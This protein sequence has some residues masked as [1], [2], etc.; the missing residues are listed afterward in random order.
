M[1]A[2][3]TAHLS[4]SIV[5]GPVRRIHRKYVERNQTSNILA[6]NYFARPEV[7]LC[8]PVM[9]EHAIGHIYRMKHDI[10][11]CIQKRCGTSR[12]VVQT[13]NEYI[14]RVIRVFEALYR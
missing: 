1:A 8:V 6:T 9:L 10:K 4:C 3:L 14:P 11:F 5:P 7:R 13:I 12:V 2:D